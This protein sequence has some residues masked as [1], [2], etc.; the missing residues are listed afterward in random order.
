LLGLGL[1]LLLATSAP[2]RAE[3]VKL[4]WKFKAGD[5][6]H[7]V[8]TQEAG[9]DMNSGTMPFKTRLK[10]I[11]DLTWAVQAVDAG[12]MASLTQTIDRLRMQMDAPQAMKAV[13]DSASGKE[14]E[15]PA[16]KAIGTMF[17]AMIDKPL[18]LFKMSSQG[19]ILECKFSPEM[20][21]QIEKS[22]L[23]KPMASM[24]SQ[25]GMKGLMGLAVLPKEAIVPGK[26]WTEEAA[27]GV[28]NPS[29]ASRSRRSMSS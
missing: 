27:T 28:P 21:S 8:A 19:K 23:L 22:P 25:E 26:S 14:P 10:T 7:Y 3:G 13:Y 9:S 17:S 12:G 5:K 2:A 20:L 29:T 1:G 11:I 15:G 16:A 18:S 6:L 4:A 24:F